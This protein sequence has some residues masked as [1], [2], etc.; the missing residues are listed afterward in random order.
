MWQSLGD[1]NAGLRRG[2][3]PVRASALLPLV[4]AWSVLWSG[5][6]APSAAAGLERGADDVPYLLAVG[7]GT[8][9]WLVGVVIVAA[10][11]LG[12]ILLFHTLVHQ[13][14]PQDVRQ[15]P[16]SVPP[17]PTDVAAAVP[18]DLQRGG[19]VVGRE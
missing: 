14:W 6:A 7:I 12:G 17:V 2:G 18:E 15:A 1:R 10:L 13:Y 11:L 16:D 5:V 19:A 9:S 4:L 3:T 8:L